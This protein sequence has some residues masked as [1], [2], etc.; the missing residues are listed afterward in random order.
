MEKLWQLIFPSVSRPSYF[1]KFGISKHHHQLAQIIKRAKSAMKSVMETY[2][3]SFFIIITH[4][5]NKTFVALL[6]KV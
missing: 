3:L 6:K 1:G 5:V 4:N 2:K